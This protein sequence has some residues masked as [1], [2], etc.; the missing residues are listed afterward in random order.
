MTDSAFVYL[1]L[2]G[3]PVRV[4]RAWFTQRRGVLA[5]SFRYDVA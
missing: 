1:E 3:A 5:T 2:D 4:G